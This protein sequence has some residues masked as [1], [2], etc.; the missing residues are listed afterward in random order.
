MTESR[1][2]FVDKARPAITL[3]AVLALAACAGG[4]SRAKDAPSGR[5]SDTSVEGNVTTI[6]TLSGSV[7][8]A[9]ARLEETLSI[10]V[11]SGDEPYMLGRVVGVAGT[12][13][14]LYVLDSS[15][16]T[17]RVYDDSGQYLF[18]IG[19]EGDGPGEFRRPNALL[20]AA[21]GRVFVSAF[22][23]DRITEFD[24]DGTA[25]NT[26]PL[27]Q[28]TR[29]VAASTL[30]LADDGTLYSSGRVGEDRT[31]MIPRNVDNGAAAEPIFPPGYDYEPRVF[32]QQL[33]MGDMTINVTHAVPF[34]PTMQWALSPKGAMVAGV[35]SD[36]SFDIVHRD[37]TVTRVV[38]EYEPIA[39]SAAERNW[40]IE[41]ITAQLREGDP[42]WTWQGPEMAAVKPAYG[43]LLPDLSGRVWVG[44]PGP[45][46]ENP[47]C[48]K[49]PDTG[50]WSPPCWA[51]SILYDVFDM[52]GAF[53]GSVDVPEGVSLG[54]R[55]WI[56]GDE[57][58]TT[59]E[60]ELGV[61]RVKRY[62]LVIPTK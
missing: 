13:D 39:L 25:I 32:E 52:E 23:Q 55:P 43:Q 60:D 30:V 51:D 20:V 24:A 54:P 8:G 16:P 34:S 4:D 40:H 21:D 50:V 12:G 2:V 38:R 57:I 29:F 46:V 37:G 22:M 7:W 36:Y 48:E 53:L 9:T 31:G 5:E 3:L 33:R 62:R 56:E 26:Y 58:V 49:Q 47:D 14:R 1:G 35:S 17:V 27:N 45:G 42:E 44:R 61:I 11:D 28:G 41:Q 15:V 59:I 19:S 18:D 10:G 6:R